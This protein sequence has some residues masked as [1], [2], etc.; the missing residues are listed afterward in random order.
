MRRLLLLASFC[1]ALRAADVPS[2]MRE[3]ATSAHPSYPGKT[4]AV[5]L[6]S[7]E[8]L[9]MD[10]TGKQTTQ[11]RKVIKILS[12]EGRAEA[13]GSVT[14][15]QKG[16]KVRDAKAYLIYSSGKTKEYSKK[17]FVEGEASS[18]STLYSTLRYLS[19]SAKADVDP[20][21][22][23][24]F[25]IALEEK[26]VFSQFFFHPQDDLPHLLSR[27]Q[28]TVP[29]GWTAESKA[30]NDAQA[31]AEVNG[32]TYTWEE[33]NLPPF[34]REPS[35]PGMRAQLP[36]VAISVYPPG[37]GP[38]AGPVACFR[39]WRDVS[40]WESTLVDPQS[41]LSPA[42]EA[43]AKEL[44]AHATTPMAK[45]QAIAEFTQK[46]R[47]V[48][49]LTNL[50]R[51]G[52]YVPNK[53]DEILRAGY[54][55]C[56]DKANLMRSLLKAVGITSW[57]VGIYSGD[58]RFTKEDFPS[59]HQFNHAILAISVAA[60]TK[61]PAVTQDAGLGT[62]LLFDPTDPYVPLGYLPGHEQN[63]FALI[64]AGEQGK[65]L[66]TPS[67]AAS[68]NRTERKWTMRIQPDGSLEGE[69]EENALGQSAFDDRAMAETLSKDDYRKTIE[70]WVT[71]S[72]P[73]AEI[74]L[75]DYAYNPAQARFQTRMSF[76][77][78]NYAKVMRGKLWMIRSSPL[79]FFGIPNVNSAKREQ[80]LIVRPL[81]LAE[82]VSWAFP[83]NLKIDE[84]PDSDSLQM[85]YGKFSTTWKPEG[86]RIVVER[87]LMLED[88]I[89][90]VGEY[91]RARTFFSRFR[92]AEAAPIVLLAP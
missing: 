52:G 12:G 28:L 26:R 82:K 70:G 48:L 35:A 1:L 65:L 44:T 17:D 69:L 39:T 87:N 24:G 85:P 58:P 63:S 8:K 32:Q 57:P 67:T 15:D 72:I 64:T 30:Y 4:K 91:A 43:K 3:F 66:R 92:G 10:E 59:P 46:I 20:G 2:W 74:S 90:P 47:Y 9:V 83:E 55:D 56:K 86:S 77:A 51:G 84:V 49:V 61:L 5:V 33:R 25:E 22:V 34:D 41:E 78:A 27:F 45:I 40:V 13:F 60:D 79:A 71:N 81:F 89:L 53:A 23:F 16:S 88:T 18:G 75:L 36:R 68:D 37:A 31:K 54:G 21:S 11:L 19:I 73:G 29:A 50:A 62:L 14:Y 7:E 80:P 38:Q 6:F 42:I 76:K